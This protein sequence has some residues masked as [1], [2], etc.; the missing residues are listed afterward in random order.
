MHSWD[1]DKIFKILPFFNTYIEK[2]E[3]KKLNNVQLLKELPFYDELSI[4]KNKTAFSGYAQSYKIEI[5]DKRDVIVQLKASK[6]SI[7]ELF[8]NL[9]IELKGFRYQIT[10]AVL[11]S[12]V[13][14]SN[15]IEYSRVYFN[16]LTKTVINNKFKL[17]QLFQEIIYRLENW[18]SNGSGWIVEEIISQFLNV[19]SYLPL[20]GSTYIK[21]PKELNHPM[22]GLINIQNNDNK[23]FL[24]CHVR[25]FNLDGV[26]LNRITK[27]DREMFKGLNYSSAD[28]PV[29][30][31]DYGK[32]KVLNKINVNVFCYENKPIYPV[33]LSDQCFNDSLDL[34]LISNDFTSHYVYIKD[35]NR[36]CLIKLKIKTRNT[37]VK[38]FLQCFSSE[39]VLKE[40]KKGCLLIN[41]GQNV[42]LEKGFIEFKNFNRQIPVPFK[43][44][45]DFECLLKGVDC[46]VDNDCFSYTNKHQ[47]HIPCSF[48][49]KVVCVDNK[50]SKDIV[51]YRGKN[52]VLKFIKCIF[53]EYGY[54]RNVMKKHFNKNLIMTAEQNEEFEKSNICW[55][56]GKLIDLSDNKTRNHCHITGKYRRPAHWNCNINLKIS[57]KVP[58]IFHNLKG[59]DS[60]LIFKKLSKFNCKISVIPNELE[61]YMSF[62]LN[63]NIVFIDSMLFMKS[64]LGKLVKNLGSEDFKYLSEE[65][66]GEKLK[67]VKKKCIYLYEYF[68]SFK[69]FKETNLT[70]IDK[71][72]VH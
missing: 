56:G 29:S 19:S 35:F 69:K 30:K 27:K 52:A 67:L 71:F 10:L 51:L 26:K 5:V 38:V 70:D 48:A 66:S 57:K 42:K 53:K 59:Y 63:N 46:G 12:K 43:I 33:Y 61:N 24:W 31:K 45:A 40:H 1:A 37:F 60:H 62:T 14:N 32:I 20:S 55:I 36:L 22:K 41:G 72:L 6:I 44:Y 11:L 58:V 65:C 34:L 23:C 3:V 13:K 54:C 25:H 8:K 17:N 64:S 68:T 39:N 9:L 15:E 21:L 2:Q 4:A 47:D 18:V 7:V 49:Y 28:F 50:F 16:S